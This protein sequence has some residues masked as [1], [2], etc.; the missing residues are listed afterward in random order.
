MR[1]GASAAVLGLLLAAIGAGM[2]STTGSA[3]QTQTV[4][5]AF[6]RYYDN[7][8]LCFKARLSGQVSSRTAGEYVAVLRQHCGRSFS[9]ATAVAGAT[10][11]AQGFWEAE[12]PVVSRPDALV[13]ETYRA[14]WEGTLSEPVTFRGRL[15]VS[16]A[17]LKDGRQRV[18]VVTGSWPPYSPVNLKGR[19]VVLQRQ[20]GSQWTRIASARLTP[21]PV[22]YYTF[23]ATVTVPRRGWTLRALVPVKSAAPCFVASRSEPWRS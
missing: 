15:T 10:T 21:H 3:A 12:L 20:T 6:V 14:R 18:T 17:R 4:T 9:T 23:V 7:A 19:P 13:S 2:A 5:L 11:R 1:R 16:G 8:C 22:K